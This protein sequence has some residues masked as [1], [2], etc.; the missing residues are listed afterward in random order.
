MQ[1]GV[2]FITAVS[3]ILTR[4]VSFFEFLSGGRLT[5]LTKVKLLEQWER[6]MGAFSLCQR[7]LPSYLV[8]KSC[9]DGHITVTLGL[10]SR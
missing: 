4:S 1:V 7:G 5:M 9:T 6:K 8:N 10:G 3:I 2:F